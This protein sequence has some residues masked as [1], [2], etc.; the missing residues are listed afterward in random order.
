MQN[1]QQLMIENQNQ[2]EQSIEYYHQNMDD[3]D[4]LDFEMSSIILDN[5]ISNGGILESIANQ[6]K[7]FN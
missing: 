2:H 5:D 1:L 4:M 3:I 6:R 7:S